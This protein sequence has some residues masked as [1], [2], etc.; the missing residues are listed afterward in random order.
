MRKAHYHYLW[1]TAI[2]RVWCPCNRITM[3]T[4][5]LPRSIIISLRYVNKRLFCAGIDSRSKMLNPKIT[6]TKMRVSGVHL[7][8]TQR[9]MCCDRLTQAVRQTW[10][11]NTQNFM[12]FLQKKN[13]SA[14]QSFTLHKKCKKKD[15]NSVTAIIRNKRKFEFFFT[16]QFIIFKFNIN[17]TALFLSISI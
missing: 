1:V 8:K 17:C 4:S 9:M 5:C 6:T 15:C 3:C 2:F 7:L 11:C 10:C 16:F 13:L 12:F 14:G